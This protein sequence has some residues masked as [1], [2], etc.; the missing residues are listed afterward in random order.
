MS[1]RDTEFIEHLNNF[2]AINSADH[3]EP[4]LP[5]GQETERLPLLMSG[6]SSWWYQLCR[7]RWLLTVCLK[8]TDHTLST[9]VGLVWQ[10]M[11]VFVL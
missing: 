9:M 4:K 6:C 10:D 7:T 11:K 1:L 3:N 2:T 8:V 5:K